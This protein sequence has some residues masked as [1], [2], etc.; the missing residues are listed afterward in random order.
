M[1]CRSHVELSP[2]DAATAIKHQPWITPPS[3]QEKPTLGAPN[4]SKCWCA[5]E[6]MAILRFE[7]Q[8]FGST[9]PQVA[10]QIHQILYFCSLLFQLV[11]WCC[12]P[13]FPCR[14]SGLCFLNMFT[15]HP[16][17]RSCFEGKI[18]FQCKTSTRP[19][20]EIN[21]SNEPGFCLSP[22]LGYDIW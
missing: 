20:L 11:Q 5:L 13:S 19:W 21:D 4:D 6:S 7:H 10:C 15:E 3:I 9:P 8:M 14:P 18:T 16:M 22:F 2:C 17:V 1:H 12:S